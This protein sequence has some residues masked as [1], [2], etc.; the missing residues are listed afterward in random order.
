MTPRDILA[1]SVPERHRMTATVALGVASNGSAVALLATSMWLIVSAAA[2]PPILWLSFAIV[3]VR[4]F[5]L[6]RAFFRYIERL[7]GHDA[8]FRRLPA[9][10]VRLFERLAERA[11]FGISGVQRG[12]A[13]SRFVRDIDDLQFYPLRVLASCW[14]SGIVTLVTVLALIMFAPIAGLGMAVILTAGTSLA[15]FSVRSRSARSARDIAPARGAL[16]DTVYDTVSNWDVLRAFGADGTARSQVAIAGEALSRIE[17]GVARRSGFASAILLVS[18]GLSSA[19]GMLAIATEVAGGSLTVPMAAVIVLIPIALGDLLGVFPIA[20]SARANA[21]AAANRIAS[22]VPEDCPSEIPDE[23]LSRE[24]ESGLPIGVH[25]RIVLDRVSV[26]YPGAI[27][28]ALSDISFSIEPG[29][30]VWISGESGSGK[31]SLAHALVRFL[32]VQGRATLGGIELGELGAANVRSLV[33]LCEQQPWLFHTTIRGNLSFARPGVS[34][35]DFVRV[36]ERVGLADWVSAR[37]GLDAEV[38]ERGEL[39]SGG[40]AQRIALARSLLIDAPI[41]ICDEPT[42][43]VHPELA[44]QIFR[45]IAALS[46]ERTVIIMSHETL[47]SDI[48]ARRLRIEGGRLR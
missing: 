31:S 9:L 42:A 1:S 2:H 34:D 4:A 44:D 35:D 18:V 11:P 12:D 48:N 39:V 43:N 24:S 16:T 29:E 33:V 3:G 27:E 20:L 22:V 13:L 15:L 32:T 21:Q 25:S 6:G 17:R 8:V 47:P 45:D 7:V 41:L 23:R 14:S 40:Q 5:A 19:W 10:R 26:R 38:G 28:L 46:L 30:L 37:G 36:L